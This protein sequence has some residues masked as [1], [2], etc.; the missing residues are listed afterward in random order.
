LEQLN[1]EELRLLS[2]IVEELDLE[3]IDAAD[4]DPESPLFDPN[5]D[6]SLGLDSIDALEISLA[7]AKNYD[8]HLVAENEDNKEI[9]YSIRSLTRYVL[10]NCP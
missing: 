5:D 1:T 3:D 10:D 9:F 6:E 7:I 8:V 2:I 4:V